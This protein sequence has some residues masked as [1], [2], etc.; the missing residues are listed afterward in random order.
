ML[1]RSF[2][3]WESFLRNWK[4]LIKIQGISMTS[5]QR[6]NFQR[7]GIWGERN[8][9]AESS[10]EGGNKVPKAAWMPH[11]MS[12]VSANHSHEYFYSRPVPSLSLS[13]LLC[14]TTQSPTSEREPESGLSF[15]QIE[16]ISFLK[17]PEL[18]CRAH[19]AFPL[20]GLDLVDNLFKRLNWSLMAG[21]HFNF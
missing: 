4:I 19:I 5:N 16:P 18:L 2:D 11:S 6:L 8:L 13:T 3:A 14:L 21:I 9:A 10:G 1:S 15:C 20:I 17:V 7:K 12:T